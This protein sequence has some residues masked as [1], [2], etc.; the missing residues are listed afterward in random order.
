M[1]HDWSSFVNKEKAMDQSNNE[2]WE[3]KLLSSFQEFFSLVQNMSFMGLPKREREEHQIESRGMDFHTTSSVH[4][5]CEFGQI[6]WA[7][8]A[9]FLICIFGVSPSAFCH[10][11]RCCRGQIAQCMS[12]LFAR[13]NA[14]DCSVWYTSQCMPSPAF[15]SVKGAGEVTE[16]PSHHL[17]AVRLSHYSHLSFVTRK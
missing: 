7:S 17:G 11:Q 14:T 6:I 16:E 4:M 10:P 1:C 5:I 9:H 12:Q 3:W 8:V 2:L 13:L 15:C